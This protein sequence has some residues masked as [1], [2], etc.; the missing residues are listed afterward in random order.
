MLQN[1]YLLMPLFFKEN[2]CTGFILFTCAVCNYTNVKHHVTWLLRPKFMH[3]LEQN[4]FFKVQ[5]W[6]CICARKPSRVKKII[7]LRI[8]H[9]ILPMPLFLEIQNKYLKV[10]CIFFFICNPLIHR[11]YNYAVSHAEV[12]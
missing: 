6:F 10:I 4:L 12:G 11:F 7:S 5:K 3:I 8:S 9:V 1:I 2:N